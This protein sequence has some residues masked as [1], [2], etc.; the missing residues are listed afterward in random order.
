MDIKE[1]YFKRLKVYNN[2]NYKIM[3]LYSGENKI[4]D[5]GCGSGALCNAIK[6]INSNAIIYGIDVSR[7][8][9]KI[10]SKSLNKFYKLDLDND[11]LPA[12]GVHFDLIVCGDVLEHLK[13]PDLLLSNLKKYLSADGSIIISVPN[14]AYWPLRM[15]LL[16]G[17]FDYTETGI[18]DATHLRFFTRKTIADM[19]KVCGYNII[20]VEYIVMPVLSTFERVLLY[21]KKFNLIAIQFVFKIKKAEK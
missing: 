3:E 20:V 1:K 21:L 19:I 5:I 17:N 12:F 15:A 13:K 4:L 6:K 2:V 7:E 14:I 11:P 8:A 10:A 16:R 9:G 18:L